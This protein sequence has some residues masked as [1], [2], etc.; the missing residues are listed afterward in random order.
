MKNKK[1]FDY[2]LKIKLEL[3]PEGRENVPPKPVTKFHFPVEEPPKGDKA[4]IMNQV[5]LFCFPD[6]PNFPRR[7]IRKDEQFLT[8]V[9][10]DVSGTKKYGYCYREFSRKFQ[11]ATLSDLTSKGSV[12]KKLPVAFCILTSNPYLN[13]FEEMLLEL[14]KL[15]GDIC[16]LKSAL[17]VVMNYPHPVPGQNVR[18]MLGPE[19]D[20]KIRRATFD[21]NVFGFLNFH[22]LLSCLDP[23]TVTTLFIS[24]LLEKRFIFISSK[25]GVLGDCVQAMASLLYPFQWQHVFIPILPRSMLDIVCAPM[26]FV[27]GVLEIDCATIMTMPVEEAIYVDLDNCF[28][29]GKANDY[30][31]LP[32]QAVDSLISTFIQAQNILNNH[33]GNRRPNL[34]IVEKGILKFMSRLLH[35]F[36]SFVSDGKFDADGFSQHCTPG[37]EQY[38]SSMAGSQLWNMFTQQYVHPESADPAYLEPFE[39]FFEQYTE[40][41]ENLY[42]DDFVVKS[43]WLTKQGAKSNAWQQRWFTLTSK[44]LLYK[45]AKTDMELAGT[46][47][48]Q[49]ITSVTLSDVR[50]N[51]IAITI[52]SGRTY[53]AFHDNALGCE[54]W[55]T[56]LNYRMEIAKIQRESVS[57]EVPSLVK[58]SHDSSSDD[59]V[60]PRPVPENPVKGRPK[61][62]PRI[63]PHYA[64]LPIKPKIPL[65]DTADDESARLLS[66]LNESV[67]PPLPETPFIEGTVQETEEPKTTSTKPD[68]LTDQNTT[69]NAKAQD[70]GT[71]NTTDTNTVGNT[72]TTNELVPR[73]KSTPKIQDNSVTPRQGMPNRSV[74]ERPIVRFTGREQMEGNLVK[75]LPPI[76]NKKSEPKH[77][78]TLP[79]KSSLD[80]NSHSTSWTSVKHK[81][82]NLSPNHLTFGAKSRS[83]PSLKAS[84]TLSALPSIDTQSF[85]TEP[86]K[87]KNTTPVT[88]DRHQLALTRSNLPLTVQKEGSSD[89]ER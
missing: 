72:T 6:A 74:T 25:V 15:S 50:E 45:K 58:E 73:Q 1:L 70:L 81:H 76:P 39:K 23:F 62:L 27:L 80:T 35:S 42:D 89:D 34:K 11:Q 26:P 79:K 17:Q 67:L 83:T 63:A 82:P 19:Q 31:L 33:K 24:M 53:L 3:D 8:F 49:N 13:F 86:K 56:V 5:P 59:F 20:F 77:S 61:P 88:R 57:I 78:A 46:I 66:P 32:Y 60:S 18:I 40:E 9:L 7:T 43:G 38:I 47:P 12:A 22:K 28:V 51:C 48:I 71:N 85:N 44:A 69:T 54:A 29:T 37:F 16:D 4:L 21:E 52:L 10:T 75:V 64:T 65:I 2:Y 41:K 84:L 87:W 36:K 68:L 55:I 30:Q 14:S